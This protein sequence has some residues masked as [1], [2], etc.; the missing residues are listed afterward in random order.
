MNGNILLFISVQDLECSTV[1]ALPMS[2]T[3]QSS[4]TETM[5]PVINET[6]L[7]NHWAIK[8]RF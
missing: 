7:S 2:L 4:P 1:H 5:N 8:S 6:S 3:Q